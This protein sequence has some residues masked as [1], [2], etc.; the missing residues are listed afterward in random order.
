MHCWSVLNIDN[1]SDVA[2]VLF[3]VSP[4]QVIYRT[5]KHPTLLRQL[6]K[7]VSGKLTK[8]LLHQEYAPTHKC[9]CFNDCQ[10]RVVRRVIIK[11]KVAVKYSSHGLVCCVEHFLMNSIPFVG[12]AFQAIL[13]WLYRNWISKFASLEVLGYCPMWMYLKMK[14]RS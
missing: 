12:R 11:Y 7:N 8:L 4:E 5:L 2:C 6:R 3:R 1:Q 10:M 9:D 14:Q 13:T